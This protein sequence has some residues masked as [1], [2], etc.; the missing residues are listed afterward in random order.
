ML[1]MRALYRSILLFMKSHNFKASDECIGLNE[2]DE[3]DESER[4]TENKVRKIKLL[5]LVLLK[6]NALSV[7]SESRAVIHENRILWYK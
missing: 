5:L 7:L 3:S 4:S 6:L 2:S 1:W